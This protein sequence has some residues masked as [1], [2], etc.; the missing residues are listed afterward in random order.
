LELRE[1]HRPLSLK[2]NMCTAYLS[3]YSP[4]IFYIN[5]D[6]EIYTENI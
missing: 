4:V 3:L 2:L 6:K 1:I 5:F